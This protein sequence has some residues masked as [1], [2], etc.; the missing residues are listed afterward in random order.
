[1]P[2]VILIDY[3][4]RYRTE[5]NISKVWKTLKVKSLNDIPTIFCNSWNALLYG[6]FWG[7]TEHS[8]LAIVSKLCLW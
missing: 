3:C 1:M 8:L 4:S 2:D 7:E 5:T 6:G